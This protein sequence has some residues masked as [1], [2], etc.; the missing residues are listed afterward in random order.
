VDQYGYKGVI[1]GCDFAGAIG[2]IAGR[3]TK[4]LPISSSDYPTPAKRPSY[5]VMDTSDLV[6]DDGIEL[7]GWEESLGKC[8]GKMG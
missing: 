4:L 7:K 1:V 5:S 3:E 6:G 2:R 8:I